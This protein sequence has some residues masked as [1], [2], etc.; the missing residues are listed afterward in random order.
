M[1]V[2]LGDL[3]MNVGSVAR[4]GRCRHSFEVMVRITLERVRS[5][6]GRRGLKNCP[7][8]SSTAA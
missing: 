1:T 3:R 6:P 8:G 4:E 7:V 2:Y 5:T